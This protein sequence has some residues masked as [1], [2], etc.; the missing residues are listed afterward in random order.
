MIFKGT[1]YACV[2]NEKKL[3]SFVNKWHI[4]PTNKPNKLE[5]NL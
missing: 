2:L 5:K 4:E 3:D 1:V